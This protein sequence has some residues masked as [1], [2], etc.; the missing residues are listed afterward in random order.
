MSTLSVN[1]VQ[2][3]LAWEQAEKNYQ[4]LADL[5]DQGSSNADLII[6]PEMFATGFSMNSA[7]VAEPMEG[8][9]V[10]WLQQQSAN[11]QCA[12][13]GSLAI[14]SDGQIYNRFLFSAPEQL[15]CYDKRHLFR[16]GGEHKRYQSGGER[17]LVDFKAWRILPQVCY[18][19]RFPVWSRNRNDYDLAIYVA[20]WPAQ[21]AYHWRQLL[22]ARAIENQCYVIGVNRVGQDGNGLDYAGDSLV[23]SPRGELLLDMADRNG[24]EGCQI[25]LAEL[26]Q[27]RCDFPAHMDADRFSLDQE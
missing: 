26:E 14:T 25:S 9:S 21:R 8:P 1:L 18:D 15:A 4:H 13:G 24:I 10:N 11:R 22:I 5:M 6:L 20:N 27:Y 16:M 3:Q 12:I 19:L 7:A 2:T 17:K 23:V